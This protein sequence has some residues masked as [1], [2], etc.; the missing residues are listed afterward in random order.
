MVVC[1]TDLPLKAH[2][3]PVVAHASPLHSVA[4]V[5][6][7]ALGAVGL[8]RRTRDTVVGLVRTLLG[9]TEDHACRGPVLVSDGAPASSEGA[10]GPRR[11][12]A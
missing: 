1:L 4:V 12:A 7:P 10:S 3:R 9:D 2:R 5:C 8:R 11:T 6:L